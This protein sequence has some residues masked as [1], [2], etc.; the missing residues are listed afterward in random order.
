M[1]GES[2]GRSVS[3]GIGRGRGRTG[4]R[5]RRIG[6]HAPPRS[7][8]RCGAA[9]GAQCEALVPEDRPL[10]VVDPEGE[11]V[12]RA[13]P[14]RPRMVLAVTISRSSRR[15]GSS[16]SCASRPAHPSRTTGEHPGQHDRRAV[17]PTIRSTTQ[18]MGGRLSSTG[19]RHRRVRNRVNRSSSPKARRWSAPGRIRARWRR[20]PDPPRAREARRLPDA[21]DTDA[22]SAETGVSEEMVIPA[23]PRRRRRGQHRHP[24]ATVD[25]TSRQA[26]T[27]SSVC[28]TLATSFWRCPGSGRLHRRETANHRRRVLCSPGVAAEGDPRCPGGD[29]V[30]GIDRLVIGV[31]RSAEHEQCLRIA[32]SGQIRDSGGAMVLTASA[33]ISTQIGHSSGSVR[34]PRDG[35]TG[36]G[37]RFCDEQHTHH[38]ALADQLARRRNESPSAAPGRP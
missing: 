34:R 30:G 35:A 11:W 27:A 23:S 1:V 13:L 36:A 20:I 18:Q 21:H 4:W 7:R 2:A 15:L 14:G 22:G 17:V 24:L 12:H 26:S 16:T 3:V 6:S 32:T 33:P 19:G 31:L 10:D 29:H 28:K 9:A 25:I 5:R 8:R 38:L 37:D